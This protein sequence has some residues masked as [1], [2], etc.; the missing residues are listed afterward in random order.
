[1]IYT[2]EARLAKEAI[3]VPANFV[4][5]IGEGEHEG[6]DHLVFYMYHG[7]WET[8]SNEKKEE[9]ANYLHQ[10]WEAMHNLGI[11]STLFWVGGFPPE[12]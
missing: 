4:V 6:V 10:L 5:D 12:D 9:C 1:M 2:D 7:Q 3:P 8:F 11:K